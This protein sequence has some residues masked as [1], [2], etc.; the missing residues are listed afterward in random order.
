[1]SALPGAA[2]VAAVVDKAAKMEATRLAALV[3]VV[4]EELSPRHS[5]S[6]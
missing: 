3:V 6:P 5:R 4:E 2:V 1:L